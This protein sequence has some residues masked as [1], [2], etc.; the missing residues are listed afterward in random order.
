M[1]HKLSVFPL[2]FQ[3]ILQFVPECAKLKSHLV[4]PERKP[5]F[6]NY[7]AEISKIFLRLPNFQP[8]YCSL[9]CFI[10]L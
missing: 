3:Y 7:P 4:L 2:S 1:L 5:N 9:K 10:M 8:R 6:A